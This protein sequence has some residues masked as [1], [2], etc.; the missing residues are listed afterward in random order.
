MT[1]I[2]PFPADLARLRSFSLVAGGLACLVAGALL[3]TL[4]SG[5][6]A[7]IGLGG[8]ILATLVGCWRPALARLPY[9][10]WRRLGR[11]VARYGSLYVLGV[12]YF[13]V[14]AAVGRAGSALVLAAPPGPRSAW[15]PR[16]GRSGGPRGDVT[17][18]EPPRRS[19]VSRYVAW[20][21]ASGHA[22][23]CCLVPFLALLG[24]LEV[25]PDAAEPATTTYTLY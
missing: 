1:P 22:W 10:A 12:C 25:E 23:A 5:A 2:L 13:V 3:A 8:G 21:W 4:G 15:T 17:V 24:A 6:A 19:W 20:A 14:V 18:I 7:L 11:S 9:R 16:D